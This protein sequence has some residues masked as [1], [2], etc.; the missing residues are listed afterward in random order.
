MSSDEEKKS[1][2][3]DSDIGSKKKKR[4]KRKKK[5]SSS[6][7]E[8]DSDEEARPKKKRRRIKKNNDSSDDGEGEGEDED[9]DEEKASPN[10]SGRK[11]IRKIIKD[12]KLSKETK[13]AAQDEQDRRKRIGGRQELFNE[14]VEIKDNAIVKEVPLDIDPETKEFIIQVSKTK[15]RFF[16]L[17]NFSHIF[18]SHFSNFQVHPQICEKLKP[19]Q[20][21]GIK[22]MWEAVFESKKD[23]EEDKVPGGAILAHCMG[24]GKT[25][26]TIGLIHT[27]MMACPD[28]IRNVLVI[29]PVNTL[30]NWEDEFYKWLDDKLEDDIDVHELSG[31]K[32][33]WGR[34]DR[35]R[36][37]QKKG[38][39]LIMGYDMFR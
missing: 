24:L 22:F 3:S 13:T 8:P 28:Q 29:A 17:T 26:Q 23:I 16:Y 37:W 20:A 27:A 10:K 7:D 2:D 33:N 4:K 21:R 14:L 11:D 6:S 31:E 9:G 25:L 18:Y 30:K 1:D 34:A 38:G 35:L 32:D 36:H 15:Q 39:A 5:S 12:K 19:H